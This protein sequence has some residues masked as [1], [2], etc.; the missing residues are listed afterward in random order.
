MGFD[1]GSSGGSGGIGF[2]I[3]DSGTVDG[4]PDGNNRYYG[5]G[6][7]SPDMF[8]RSQ[9]ALQ[10]GQTRSS[11]IVFGELVGGLTA[12]NVNHTSYYND[13]PRGWRI[14]I[15]NDTGQ[16]LDIK[17]RLVRSI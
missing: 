5:G 7:G 1:S 17:W 3:I 11:D 8:V 2:E 14:A 10:D 13:S 12:D 6:V 9:L 4:L 15:D 16:S